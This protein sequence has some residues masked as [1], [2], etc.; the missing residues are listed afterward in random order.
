[1]KLYKY[2]FCRYKE[3]VK[4]IADTLS[5]EPNTSLER[6]VWWTEYV[7]RHKGA[8]FFKSPALDMPWYQYYLIDVVGLFVAV[9]LVVLYSI[10]KL[11]KYGINK[12][13]GVNNAKKVKPKTQ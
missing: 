12:I 6:V 4:E 10:C 11:T 5:D 2:V 7:I 3:K 13:T 8:P 9:A 1:M